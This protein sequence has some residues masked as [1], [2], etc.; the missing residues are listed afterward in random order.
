MS[1]CLRFLFLSRAFQ[2]K[3]T[4]SWP[5][6][7]QF[8]HKPFCLSSHFSAVSTWK[9]L[10]PT[11]HHLTFDGLRLSNVGDNES[12]VVVTKLRHRAL[13]ARRGNVQG[14]CKYTLLALAKNTFRTRTHTHTHTHIQICIDVGINKTRIYNGFSVNNVIYCDSVF[15]RR[16][17][18]RSTTVSLLGSYSKSVGTAGL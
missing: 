1:D 2:T 16:R 18:P 13:G 6:S 10:P 7:Q 17:N 14:V 3:H 15:S 8:L 9:A 11:N 5:C 12:T 4:R